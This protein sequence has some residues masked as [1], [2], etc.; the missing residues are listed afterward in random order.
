VRRLLL[1]ALLGSVASS[2]F[3]A[4]IDSLVS[5]PALRPFDPKAELRLTPDAVSRDPVGNLWILDRARGRVM[6]IDENGIG[7]S[8]PVEGENQGGT[9]KV[10]DFATSGTYLF[11]LEPPT[12]SVAL[13]DLDGFYR[14][15]VDLS[16]EIEDAGWQGLLLTRLLVDRSG[17]L[18]LIEES[19]GVVLHFDRRGRFLDAPYEALSRREAPARISDVALGID[20]EIVILDVAS[21]K[22]F[23]L[24]QNGVPRGAIA[25]EPPILEPTSLAVDKEGR[26]YLM[27]GSGRIRVLAADGAVLFDAIPPGPRPTGPHRAY[28]GEDG[29]LYRCDPASGLVHRFRIVRTESADGE[30]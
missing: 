27:E 29:L 24:S 5:V 23:S 19:Q 28:F 9:G 14:E 18:W 7:E 30:P 26:R 10:A 16:E 20:D 2:G 17:A 15:R 12:P 4:S 1:T 11:V 3:A 21:A 6:S 8:F 25:I 13:L 22:I